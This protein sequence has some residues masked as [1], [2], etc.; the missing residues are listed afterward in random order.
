MIIVG[1]IKDGPNDRKEY[2]VTL[3]EVEIDKIT[4]I[5]DKPHQ[6]GRYRPG[7]KLNISAIYNKVKKIA[8]NFTMIKLRMQETK[9]AA[10]EIDDNLPLID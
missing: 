3:T 5:A 2:Q 9:I 6:T 8:E 1:R 7:M 4:G 10:Q